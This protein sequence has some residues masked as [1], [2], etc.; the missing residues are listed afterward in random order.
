[1]NEL[2]L[3]DKLELL[4]QEDPNT[5]QVIFSDSG[6]QG[7][8]GLTGQRGLTGLQGTAGTNGINGLAGING[9]DGDKTYVHTQAIPDLVWTITHN[10]NKFPSVTIVDSASTTV[11]GDITQLSLTSLRLNFNSAFSGKAFLN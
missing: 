7:P 9:I 1:M 5:N 2:L 4:I 8:P 3:T 6:V 11:V 10:L